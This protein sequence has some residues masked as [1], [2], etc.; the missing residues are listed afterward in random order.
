MPLPSSGIIVVEKPSSVCTTTGNKAV[1]TKGI[2]EG[3]QEYRQQPQPQQQQ[4]RKVQYYEYYHVNDVTKRQNQQQQQQQQHQLHPTI[5]VDDSVYQSSQ[6]QHL[7]LGRK[8]FKIVSTDAASGN[9]IIDTNNQNPSN[10]S[11]VLLSNLTVLSKQGTTQSGHINTQSNSGQTINFVNAKNLF[12]ASAVNNKQQKFTVTTSTAANSNTFNKASGGSKQSSTATNLNP[13]Q[14]AQQQQVVST[15][16]Q[17]LNMAPTRN[18]QMI[19]RVQTVGPVPNNNNNNGGQISGGGGGGGGGG[20]STSANTQPVV[21]QQ[22][23]KFITNSIAPKTTLTATS[24]NIMKKPSGTLKMNSIN[25][26]GGT[27]GNSKLMSSNIIQ[28]PSQTVKTFITQAPSSLIHHQQN[29]QPTNVGG[30]GGIAAISSNKGKSKFVKQYNNAILNSA[31]TVAIATLPHQQTQQANTPSQHQQTFNLT[32]KVHN[33]TSVG[34]TNNKLAKINNKYCSPNAGVI[35]QLPPGTQLQQKIIHLNQ[36]QQHHQQQQQQQQHQQQHQQHQQQQHQQY[37]T[38]NSNI[39]FVNAQGTIVQQHQSNLTPQ[40]LNQKH[41]QHQHQ[42]QHQQ[43][44]Q[45]FSQVQQQQNYEVTEG[46]NIYH[47][48]NSGNTNNQNQNYTSIPVSSTNSTSSIGSSNSNSSSSN[49]S[50]NN[51]STSA[52]SSS[53]LT[54]DVMMHQFSSAA[55]GGGGIMCQTTV[56]ASGNYN[57]PAATTTFVT[58]TTHT[59]SGPTTTNAACNRQVQSAPGSRC[60]S[61]ERKLHE[62]STT[63]KTTD[64]YKVNANQ[65]QS[66]NNNGSLRNSHSGLVTVTAAAAAAAAAGINNSL[67]NASTMAITPTPPTVPSIPTAVALSML[68]PQAQVIHLQA[69]KTSINNNNTSNEDDDIM[70]EEMRPIPVQTNDVRLQ[71]LHAVLQDHTYANPM[72]IPLPTTFSVQNSGAQ[73]TTTN[74]GLLS[75]SAASGGAAAA[76]SIVQQWSLGGIGAVAA[77]AAGGMVGQQ[78]SYSLYGQQ[79]PR[80]QQDDDAHSAISNGSRVALGDIDPGEETE[81]A[82]EAEAEDDSVTRCICDLTHDD[83][84]MIC[85]DKCCAWQHVDCM[86]IDRQNIPDEYLCELCQPRVVDKIRA[87]SLQLMKRKEQTHMMLTAHAQAVANSNVSVVNSSDIGSNNSGLASLLS[88]DVVVAQQ[89]LAATSGSYN[90]SNV[91]GHGTDSIALQLSTSGVPLTTGHINLKKGTKMLKKAKDTIGG[92]GKKSKKAEKLANAA[93]GG[94]L[95]AKPPR[96]ESKK[97]TKR[98][99]KNGIDGNAT[100]MTAAEKYAANLRQWI[101]NYELAVTN[102]YSPELR[103]RLHAITK[104]PTLLQ[105]ILNT[106]NTALKE[107]SGNNLE[108]RATTVPHAGGKILI[109]NLN[110]TPNSPICELRGKYMLTTQY[111]TQN[112]SVNMNTPPPSNHHLAS[113]KAHKTP[114]PFIF[115]YQLPG[116][117]VPPSPAQTTTTTTQ[118][119]DGTYTT[120]AITIPPTQPSLPTYYKGP[121]ICVDTRTYGN[122]ARFVRRSCRPNA[123]IQH[124]FEKGTI[125]LFI[126]ALTDIR[127]STEITVRH[128][129]HDLHAVENKKS[130][131][132]VIQPTSTSC[133]CGLS[134]D[135]IFGPPLPLLPPAAKSNTSRKTITLNGG[136]SN[137][138]LNQTTSK[139]RKAAQQSINRNRST[140]S[141]GESNVGG[142]GSTTVKIGLNS[143]GV[144]SKINVRG[145]NS[146]VPSL[147]MG[148]SISQSNTSSSMSSITHDS[149]ICTSSSSPSVSIPSPTSHMHSPTQ[150]HQQQARP[151]LMPQQ[152]QQLLAS[153]PTPMLL[154]PD[155]PNRHQLPQQSQTLAATETVPTPRTSLN[156]VEIMESDSQQQQMAGVSSHQQSVKSPQ[157]QEPRPQSIAVDDVAPQEAAAAVV[158][159]TLNTAMP[160]VPDNEQPLQYVIMHTDPQT[161]HTQSCNEQQ[162]TANEPSNCS[163]S[164]HQKSSQKA[165]QQASVATL[166][167]SGRKVPV[168]N[169]RTVSGSEDPGTDQQIENENIATLTSVPKSSS[170]PKDKPKLSRED[171]KM[172]AILRAIEKMERNQQRKQEQKQSKKQNSSGSN[173]TTP[174]S[175]NKTF[176]GAEIG[177]GHVTKRNSNQ[178]S[179][180]TRKKKRK[181]TH[182]SSL[183]NP[184]SQRKPRPTR[185]NNQESA[186][187]T[188]EREVPTSESEGHSLH[189][190]PIQTLS[191]EEKT[192]QNVSALPNTLT[193]GTT[194]TEQMA[195]NV[196]QAAGLLM[197]FANPNSCG[198]D[199][200]VSPRVVE[201]HSQAQQSS[202]ESFMITAQD[203]PPSPPTPPT[204]VSSACLLIEA[205]VGPLESLDQNSEAVHAEFKFP[206]QAKTKKHMMNNWLHQAE[207]KSL[208]QDAEEEDV[209][210]SEEDQQRVANLAGGL[211]SLVQAAMSDFKCSQTLVETE[212]PQNLSIV[213][214]RVEEFIQQ[215]EA[216]RPPSS[217]LIRHSYEYEQ[218]EEKNVQLHGH[219]DL[220][221]YNITTPAVDLSVKSQVVNTSSCQPLIKMTTISDQSSVSGQIQLPVPLQV[222]TCSNNS[223]VKKRWLRQ[224]ISEESH[225][226]IH[227]CSVMTPSP[228]ATMPASSSTVASS[229]VSPANNTVNGFT[230]PLKK[231]RLLLNSKD[232]TE[233]NTSSQRDA[234]PEVSL[235]SSE[236]DKAANGGVVIL[237]TMVVGGNLDNNSSSETLE[238]VEVDVEQCDVEKMNLKLENPSET[239]VD[240]DIDVI[241]PLDNENKSEVTIECAD[242]DKNL[243]PV[244]KEEQSSSSSAVEVPTVEIGDQEDDVDILRS[245]SPG[246]EMMKPEDNL[247]KIEPEDTN[248]NDDVK[249]DVE[250]EESMAADDELAAMVSE[251]DDEFERNSSEARTDIKSEEVAVTKMESEEEKK[252]EKPQ[253]PHKIDC[254]SI[255][256]TEHIPPICKEEQ[257][258]HEKTTAVVS[259]REKKSEV[260][261]KST[262]CVKTEQL[263]FE[264]EEPK[265]KK[266]KLEMDIKIKEQPD[267]ID[268]GRNV[269]TAEADI[270]SLYKCDEICDNIATIGDNFIKDYDL[271]ERRKTQAQLEQP[272]SLENQKLSVGVVQNLNIEISKTQISASLEQHGTIAESCM[273]MAEDT[274]TP[275][276]P[277]QDPVQRH[278][279]LSDDDI[280]A[281]LHNFHKENILILQSRNKK[282][283]SSSSAGVILNST[284]NEQSK[285]RTNSSHYDG[286]DICSEKIITS[287]HNKPTGSFNSNSCS[288]NE[289]RKTKTHKRERNSSSSNGGSHKNSFTNNTC[290]Q[291]S[292]SSSSILSTTH[293]NQ[294]KN[295]SSTVHLM[296]ASTS[297]SSSTNLSK[298]HNKSLKKSF[299]GSSTSSSSSF[300]PVNCNSAS[301]VVQEKDKEKHYSRQRTTSGGS[302]VPNST[303]TGSSYSSSK[304]R[305]VNFELELTKDLHL[306]TNS[307]VSKHKRDSK[308]FNDD[309]VSQI[310]VKKHRRE[311][312]YSKDE[313]QR[314]SSSSSSNLS[315]HSSSSSSNSN[316]NNKHKS[317]NQIEKLTHNSSNST[318]ER[319]P[320]ATSPNAHNKSSVTCLTNSSVVSVVSS[321]SSTALSAEEPKVVPSSSSS[322]AA[323]TPII[324]EHP[325]LPHFNNTV[326]GSSTAG[327]SLSSSPSIVCANTVALSTAANPQQSPINIPNHLNTTT[328]TFMTAVSSISSSPEALLSS[329]PTTTPS[330]SLSNSLQVAVSVP[331]TVAVI[332]TTTT[333]TNHL[334]F[335]N[336]IY[337]KLLEN[338]SLPTSLMTGSGSS[339]MTNSSSSTS[340]NNAL[341]TAHGSAVGSLS[342]YLD[343]KLKSY[344]TLGGYV[345]HSALFGLN[346][347]NNSNS[348]SSTGSSST[349]KESS[350]GQVSASSLAAAAVNSVACSE[351]SVLTSLNA[352]TTPLKILTKT[353]SHDPR[354]NPHLTAPEPPPAPKRKLSINEYRKRMQQSTSSA[355]SSIPYH[356]SSNSTT[357]G[358][359]SPSTALSPPNSS[360]VRHTTTTSFLERSIQSKCTLNSPERIAQSVDSQIQKE[361][362]SSTGT[363]VLDALNTSS[364]T[365]SNNSSLNDS[366]TKGGISVVFIEEDTTKGQ[367]NAAP[368][369]LEKQQENLCARLKSLKERQSLNSATG[370]S[371]VRFSSLGESS[372]DYGIKKD[373]E[374][375]LNRKR[376]HSISSAGDLLDNCLEEI[377]STSTS[378]S[379]SREP[380]PERNTLTTTTTTN[381]KILKSTQSNAMNNNIGNNCST[382]NIGRNVVKQVD[383]TSTN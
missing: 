283:K 77:T 170:T 102:H 106:E 187:G 314:I 48:P 221:V 260:D 1:T 346:N 204:A 138:S 181:T 173:N 135:C 12:T 134:K 82:P 337:G 331:S 338:P 310:S 201:E 8:I 156:T 175:P 308:I 196:D 302:S 100:T 148:S 252:T 164:F 10:T 224:A 178:G 293:L 334:P 333:T 193:S 33:P 300:S 21:L 344:N 180:S 96:K 194:G 152:Q 223:S 125:H 46:G 332:T 235:S 227:N 20:G 305:Q 54:D 66:G 171:R 330:G 126:V 65:Q 36:Q 23:H 230:T 70:G 151:L 49:S 209:S 176:A 139:Q 179:A 207:E 264:E 219:Q 268:S 144:G 119:A 286:R 288:P 342:E 51:N 85:C 257:N 347:G 341:T 284:N 7:Q 30:G 91:D 202:Q 365:G 132:M 329:L 353:A 76:A 83:G 316:N 369:L 185:M 364:S 38:N 239:E 296:T 246:Q 315:N 312:S 112:S 375:D 291:I 319:K 307:C 122:E 28:Q 313:Q 356:D 34:F 4:Q 249:I 168:K 274:T 133:A 212:E 350:S 317:L 57:L 43:Q 92:G 192:T 189:S 190:P 107:C 367:F 18:L 61:I 186:D 370:S 236:D 262:N 322:L 55:G 63:R 26:I 58:M 256:Y 35:S 53:L 301:N 366:L 243:A 323:V 29:I 86:G 40:K 167:T 214:Q 88:N 72:P 258:R 84:Y 220:D 339:L 234:T 50:S 254:K 3:G 245:P 162:S 197:A 121:E 25:A 299:S 195:N 120:T 44:Y 282:S 109:S 259:G 141:S 105:S 261:L 213:A 14:Y 32:T 99:S 271:V 101:E 11:K 266:L 73:N 263:F 45:S 381:S 290:S 248:G 166:T 69:S 218:Q 355:S 146:N 359:T 240:T 345:S 378:L 265:A 150:L 161:N 200:A 78:P 80:L 149:G 75:N 9:V 67:S 377:S 71:I 81:T 335:Y 147:P 191:G 318:V 255:Q 321:I 373:E 270:K 281:R 27:T 360:Q 39:K 143:P 206:L 52:A 56:N 117:E 280:Q 158:L 123:E 205:A 208:N 183:G 358:T 244:C 89:R 336:T 68:E 37:T 289:S 87:R 226:E 272:P 325:T 22:S 273:Y 229:S 24:G 267:T 129:P 157:S 368:T 155:I 160:S 233:E 241:T 328:S 115:F 104:Q 165:P 362:L 182:K 309:C 278:K 303:N 382:T 174:T 374:D 79:I 31:G 211:D 216:P 6:A 130:N 5:L 188:I 62:T 228:T 295:S 97:N 13:A 128:E 94:G 231:R 64:Y 136:A 41:Q 269:R 225:E 324:R 247:V 110:I 16:T 285:N 42:H 253:S 142:S 294:S 371:R 238:D 153:L 380:S 159:Q 47:T 127:A 118:N 298:K 131:T 354:L 113:F 320:I 306:I 163:T 95:V 311:Y 352:N 74:Q 114:G 203:A 210:M 198:N 177:D 276:P 348:G 351:I 250:R 184:G 124:L 326:I 277:P 232:E 215:T 304:K 357:G 275:P 279:S 17:K 376:N 2:Q 372:N 251:K 292:P 349:N 343:T 237:R 98:K 199:A 60:Q 59:V 383:G 363:H 15:A 222:S 154:S 217:P 287:K 297:S 340:C 103:A 111:K 242:K 361:I 108:N 145:G 137:S 116:A 93:A 327:S 90:F 172:E 169:S 19:T 379:S 140:S